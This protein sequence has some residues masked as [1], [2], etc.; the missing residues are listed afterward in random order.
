MKNFE[1]EITPFADIPDGGG[2]AMLKNMLAEFRHRLREHGLPVDHDRRGKSWAKDDVGFKRMLVR[3]HVVADAVACHCRS[4]GLDMSVTPMTVRD[5]ISE[6]GKWRSEIDCRFI[7]QAIEV[8]GRDEKFHSDLTGFKY[9]DGIIVDT[10]KKFASKDRRPFMY[11]HVSWET[12]EYLIVPVN[13]RRMS[14][15]MTR[16]FTDRYR[17]INDK[18]YVCPLSSCISGKRLFFNLRRYRDRNNRRN[19]R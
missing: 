3:G 15:W 16:S 1:K 19:S 10:V 7:D 6:A 8:K 12:G 2:Q 4:R 11:V 5:D 18:F 17:G 9:A 14:E 13:N